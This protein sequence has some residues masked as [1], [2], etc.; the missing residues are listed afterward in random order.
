M[1]T[2]LKRHLRNNRGNANVSRM[3]MIAVV[4]VVGAILL[5]MT[6]SAFRN[7][8]N[9]W[10]DKVQS[11]WFGGDN[12]Y[13][14]LNDPYVMYERNANGSIK[15][16]N[17]RLTYSDGS[18]VEISAKDIANFPNGTLSYSTGGYYGGEH[19]DVIKNGWF[20]LGTYYDVSDFSLSAD[21]KTLII[22][23]DGYPGYCEFV[24]Y[25]PEP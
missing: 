4:F 2:Y 14:A 7:P 6:T 5:V 10:F 13:Y 8:I 18:Y 24:A 11:G 20:T 25:I 17:Y 21:G 23:E 16:L 9:R 12:G 15:G 19:E 22:S 3:T 1:F